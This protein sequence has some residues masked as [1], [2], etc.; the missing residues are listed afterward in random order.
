VNANA[1]A[2]TALG[3]LNSDGCDEVG[4]RYTGNGI[5]G[6]EVV[7][8]YDASGA[9]CGGRT[10][11][12]SVRISSDPETGMVG[13]GLGVAAT[14][15][16]RFLND[17]R[18]FVAITANTFP[19]DGRTQAAVLLIDTAQINALRPASGERLV[20]LLGGGLTPLPIVY[21]ERV[22]GF[23]TALAG[24]VDLNGDGRPELVVSA[25]GASVVSDG[26]GSVFVFRGGLATTGARDTLMTLVGDVNE[27]GN[28]G[29]DVELV[30]GAG[31]SP[32]FLV[33]GAPRSY[34][35]GTLAGTAFALPIAL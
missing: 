30:R 16:G 33:I 13:F 22:P 12:S 26:E 7:F 1:F 6:F 8:G 29:Q 9:R 11:A 20:P 28:F 17:A 21:L 23:G 14:R 5:S 31:S 18:D 32:P 15:V 19:V 27:R 24:N 2:A 10:V 4:Y 25:P 3:D 34:R 35:T